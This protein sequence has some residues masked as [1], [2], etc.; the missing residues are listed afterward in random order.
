M[1]LIRAQEIMFT[2]PEHAQHTDWLVRRATM[3]IGPPKSMEERDEI[4]DR[5]FEAIEGL[6]G[7]AA[8]AGL[9]TQEADLRVHLAAI[10]A[11]R[12]DEE[13]YQGHVDWILEHAPKT[14]AAREV[15]MLRARRDRA[16]RIRV[17]S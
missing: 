15:Q 9:T 1:E 12:G 8:K 4:I 16:R 6:R 14:K 10:E 3:D 13:A 5:Y 2:H 17:S 7:E 11:D